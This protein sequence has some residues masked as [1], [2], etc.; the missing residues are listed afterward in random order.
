MA[1]K[2]SSACAAVVASWERDKRWAA[3]MGL[4]L[5]LN[6]KAGKFEIREYD[7]DGKVVASGLPALSNVERVLSMYHRIVT[8]FGDTREE[9]KAA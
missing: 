6:E 7:A 3:S 4:H 2:D 8:Q 9:R 1:L 5:S